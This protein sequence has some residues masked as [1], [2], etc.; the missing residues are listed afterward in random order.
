[1][2]FFLVR[3]AAILAVSA[4]LAFGA[5]FQPADLRAH[6]ALLASD[7][8][9]G[10]DTPSRGLDLAAEY[11]AV[12]FRRAGLSPQPD[13]TYFQVKSAGE[14]NVVGVLYGIDPKLM[15]EFVL[16]TAHYDHTGIC[17][18]GKPDSICNGANDNASG[19]ASMIESARWLLKNPP[20][21]SVLFI[22]YF[23][24]EQGLFGSIHYA[25]SPIVPLAATV[26]Q[27][28]FEQTGRTDDLQGLNR[29]TLELTGHDYSDVA[30][31]LAEAAHPFG[32]KIGNRPKWSEAA[33]VRS[34]NL[35]LAKR[36]IPAHTVAVAF[37]FPDYHRPGDEWHKLDYDNMALVTRAA[38]AGIAALAN[39][40]AR[41]MWLEGS[42]FGRK[43]AEAGKSAAS[44][45]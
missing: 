11:I 44:G 8:L 45:H 12:Q 31:I 6:V 30:N 39:R 28:N 35:P 42:P 33:F 43:E 41:P 14:R 24:E 27:I 9:E 34:D 10:R 18:E 17:A 25:E 40:N 38:A 13:G 20:R 21:R 15:N 16:V 29:N 23:G 5:D 3:R 4:A 19:V 32:V 26:A 37:M 36:G 2:C 1:M 22:A 7:L